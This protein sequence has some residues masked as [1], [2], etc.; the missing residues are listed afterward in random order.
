MMT[1]AAPQLTFYGYTYQ[2]Y[3]DTPTL[4]CP[5]FPN[6]EEAEKSREYTRVRGY[7][8]SEVFEVKVSNLPVIPVGAK[9]C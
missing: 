8:V 4:H 9:K 2:W 7:Y 5:L 6:K 1:E 3:P